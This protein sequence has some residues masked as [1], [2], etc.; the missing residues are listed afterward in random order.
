MLFNLMFCNFHRNKLE[1]AA[2][3]IIQSLKF[4]SLKFFKCVEKVN[5]QKALKNYSQDIQ[6]IF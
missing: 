6:A 2:N 5:I 3:K 1:G 4:F